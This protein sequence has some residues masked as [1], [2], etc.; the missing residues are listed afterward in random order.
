MK[1]TKDFTSDDSACSSHHPHTYTRKPIPVYERQ[2]RPK[3][4]IL[5][6]EYTCKVSFGGGARLD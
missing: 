1:Q 5:R 2:L 6:T 4:A 3:L